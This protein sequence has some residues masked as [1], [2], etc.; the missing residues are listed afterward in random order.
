MK[1]LRILGF[2]LLA[3]GAVMLVLLLVAKD[4]ALN[5]SIVHLVSR[6]DRRVGNEVDGSIDMP[7]ALVSSAVVMF[8]GVW[9]AFY[10]PRM[11]KKYGMGGSAQPPTI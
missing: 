7:L 8:A 1:S 3:Y 4:W 6:T 11:L 5:H 9:F 10:I 2:V